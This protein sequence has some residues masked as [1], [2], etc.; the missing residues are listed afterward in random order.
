MTDDFEEWKKEA[1]PHHESVP[2][3]FD[4]ELLAELEEAEAARAEYAGMLQA[5]A[6]LQERIAD[7]SKEVE[8]KTRVLTFRSIG[9]RKWRELLAE[10]P[11]TK[12]QGALGADHN[13]ETFPPAAMAATCSEP[14]LSLEQATWIFEELPTGVVDRVWAAVLGANLIGGDEKKAV[15]TAVPPASEKK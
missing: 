6:E 5:P 15:A 7:L 2:L 9:R 13:P 3:C 14:G 10:H 11:P 1:T 12:Q 8:K 4:R